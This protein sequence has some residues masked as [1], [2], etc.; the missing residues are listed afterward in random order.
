MYSLVEN[1]VRL[2]RI[3]SLLD[4]TKGFKVSS[5]MAKHRQS[6]LQALAPKQLEREFD[7]KTYLYYYSKDDAD[8]LVLK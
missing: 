8:K 5:Y 7:S 4:W 1:S 6:L 2:E 3:L